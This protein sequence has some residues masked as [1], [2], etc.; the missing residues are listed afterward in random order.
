MKRGV[1]LTFDVECSMGGA[2]QDSGLRPVPPSRAIWGEYDGQQL[3]LPLIVQILQERGLVATFFVEAFTDEQGYPGAM[4]RVCEFLLDH[5]QDVQLHVHPNHKHYG[6]AHQG[7]PHPRT[8]AMS[9]LDA[10]DQ[11]ALL[12]EGID[13]L[14]QWTGR[15]PVAFRAGNLAASE[16]TLQQLA[17]TGIL[18]DS[19]YSFPYAGQRC[20][21]ASEQ[22]YNGS[23]WYGPV[24]EMALSGFRQARLPG[25]HA[26]KPLDLVGISFEE[27]RD[28]VDATC[29]A[30][31]DSVVILHSF[32][33]FKVRNI[34]YDGGRLNRVVTR[35][36]R[37]FCDWLQARADRPAHSFS[38][39]AEAVLAGTYQASEVFPCK[40]VHPRA[41]VRKAVQAV[42]RLYW[43]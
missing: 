31:A 12:E 28:A 2:W 24:L 21:F 3:G 41:V 38:S 9:E 5:G 23:K 40:L 33:L 7:K 37:R 11:R 16:E 25:V 20:C 17:A 22:P 14:K 13:R 4:H 26:A 30:G 35:R 27:C 39:L 42:N 1:F 32:S 15:R 6:L 19:S 18:L 34:Q 36:F 8:D 29:A 43:T 10:T